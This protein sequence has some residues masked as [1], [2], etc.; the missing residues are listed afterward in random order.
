[1]KNKNNTASFTEQSEKKRKKGGL[2]GITKRWVLTTLLVIYVILAIIVISASAALNGYYER[3]VENTI[4][5]KIQISSVN[6]YFR[7]YISS[8]G[9][10]SDAGVDFAENFQYS[11]LMDLWVI[12]E[13]GKVIVSSLGFSVNPKQSMPDYDTA[14]SS[15]DGTGLWIGRNSNNEKVLAKTYIITSSSDENIGAVRMISS[16]NDLSRQHFIY[17]VIFIIFA[18][19]AA[20]LVTFSGS[21][22]IGSI[23]RP[24]RK[25]NTVARQI[26]GG[27]YNARVQKEKG[28]NDEISELSDSINYMASEIGR[29]EQVKNDFLSTVS[30]ELRTP[31]T[32]IKGWA[33]TMKDTD[34][35]DTELISSGI[36]VIINESDRLEN[37]VEQLLDFS[38]MESGRMIAHKSKIDVIELL[39]FSVDVFKGRAK[40][41]SID[42][43]YEKTALHGYAFADRDM[44]KQV[45]VNIMDNAFKYTGSGGRVAVFANILEGTIMISV[46]DNGCG[47]SEKDLPHIKEK[48]YKANVSVP[49]SGIGLAVVDEILKMHGGSF[50]IS[51]VE[52]EG[53]VVTIY[54][55]EDKDE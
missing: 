45:F 42:F 6:T 29:T 5:S 41:D 35:S 13:K 55:P 17:T 25:I 15:S 53:T 50:D 44:I 37:L 16:L 46:A 4:D 32:A 31:L 14:V 23:V 1:M 40:R 11:N 9:S 26:A 52:N 18:S 30:H 22:F 10:F 8:G 49:G 54:I 43:R 39:D 48:F 7:N 28:A 38:R 21:F 2:H 19:L 27:D 3:L 33:E 51:S 34:P 20:G 47:I 36:N 12:D 24:V